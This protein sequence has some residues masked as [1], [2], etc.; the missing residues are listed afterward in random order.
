M[1]KKALGINKQRSSKAIGSSSSYQ[2]SL[3]NMP[4]TLYS[5]E[6]KDFIEKGYTKNGN[7]YKIIQKIIQKCAVANLELYIDTG[8]DK[9]RKYRKYRNNKYNATPIEH[10]KKRLYTK[11]LEYAPED[12]SLFKLLERPNPYQTWADLFELFRLFYF[13]QGEAFLIRE[14]ALNSNIAL[15]LYAIPPSRMSHVVKNDEIVMWTYMMPDGR[16]R[17]WK[18]EDLKNVFHLKMANPLFNM[19]GSQFRG[20]SPLTAGL[21]Y[22][23]LDD[24][25]I[26]TW[27]KS[28]QNEGAKGIIS[29]NHPDKENWMNPTQTKAT[30]DQVEAK[31]HGVDNKN[32]IVVSGMPLQYTQIGLSPDAL[33]IINSIEKAGDNLC[34]LWGVPA[35][36]FEKNPTYQNQKEGGA[37][38]IRDVILPYLNKEEDA[39]NNWL[40]EPFRFEDKNKVNY[41][42]DYDTSLYDELQISLEERKNLEGKLSLN[43]LRAIDGFDAIDN[44]Y[45]DE[46]FIDTTKIPLSDYSGGNDFIN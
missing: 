26:E 41:V 19:Q 30:Q 27:I 5:W 10:V 2:L 24:Y 6:S 7:V 44:P 15:A 14:T 31:I 11:A 35:V 32:K 40:V 25:A 36:L 8:D 4:L 46:V 33:N 16:L 43:E 39:L 22:L 9:A 42:L 12:S 45:A 34:D 3:Y 13:V 23:Q 17:T 29:P 28:I 20:M 18:G 38:F 21:K 37:R 1:I